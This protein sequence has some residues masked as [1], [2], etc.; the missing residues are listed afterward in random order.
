MI[1][2]L[3]IFFGFCENQDFSIATQKPKNTGRQMENLASLTF[4]LASME[5]THASK[6][7]VHTSW[8]I[9]MELN[10]TWRVW[11]EDDFPITLV[12]FFRGSQSFI[13]R[14]GTFFPDEW[15]Q[16]IWP[17]VNPLRR[18]VSGIPLPESGLV[19]FWCQEYP[20]VGT[21]FWM[22]LD[23]ASRRWIF[24]LSFQSR[25]FH[26]ERCTWHERFPSWSSICLCN[27]KI[28]EEWLHLHYCSVIWM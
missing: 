12:R 8:K 19:K 14:G 9:N 3:F 15:S 2:F 1:Q 6:S 11:L 21:T 7:A 24:H 26:H 4:E 17:G 23:V 20:W 27:W 5:S 13:F 18:G 22:I 28:P 25:E 10:S 16:E